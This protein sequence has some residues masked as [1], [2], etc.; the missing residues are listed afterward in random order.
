VKLTTALI[1]LVVFAAPLAGCLKKNGIE[2]ANVDQERADEILGK[3]GRDALIDAAAIIPKNYSFGSQQLLPV[4]LRE[5]IGTITT[6]AN[7]ALETEKDEGGI[8]HSTFLETQDISDLVPPGQPVELV[9]D[10]IWDASEANSA[11]LDIVVDVPG[12][13]S[14]FSPTSETFNW[15]LAVKTIVVNTIGVE[16]QPAIV[17]VQAAGGAV[18]QGFDYTLRVHAQYVKDVLTPHHAWAF[19]VPTD[20]SGIIIESEKAGGE[21][22]VAAQFI[23][24]DPADE[25]VAFVDFNDIDI[26]TE[27]VFIQT[28]MPGT[29]VFYAYSMHGGFLR[30]KADVPLDNTGARPLALVETKVAD[31]SAPAP[32][33]AGKD[34]LN[35]TLAEGTLPR[36]DQAP[37]VVDF[38]TGATFPLR[39]VGYITG[40]AHTQSK[41]TLTSPLG[42]V[43][44]LTKI[45]RYEDESGSV[46]YTSDHEGSPNNLFDWQNI[47][48]GA[49]TAQVVNTSPGVEIG[50]TIL[51]YARS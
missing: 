37:A 30:V 4:Q 5:F 40:T 3:A 6:A 13:R 17:G 39:I 9:I 15:N 12:L 18:S 19:D 35:G 16:G 50:H 20:A 45:A 10:L 29:Y 7:G 31:S 33:V 44:T 1:I 27:S 48:R 11:D 14:S 23:V 38:D 49:W 25:L 8:E 2:A 32:G 41:I 22:H 47:Q 46:G 43:H 26:P 34:V 51:T 21:E 42:V 24:I 28:H 36:D